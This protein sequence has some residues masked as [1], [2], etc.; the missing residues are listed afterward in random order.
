M[1]GHSYTVSSVSHKY[2][3]LRGREKKEK[4]MLEFA[5]AYTTG[6]VK[7]RRNE[8]EKKRKSAFKR[9]LNH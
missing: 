3:D 7:E 2:R 1:L 6:I 5:K 9:L 8:K 4:G